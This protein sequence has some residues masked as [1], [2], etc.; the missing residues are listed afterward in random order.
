VAS[1]IDLLLLEERWAFAAG[2]RLFASDKQMEFRTSIS[3]A[4][5]GV[6]DSDAAHSVGQ[7]FHDSIYRPKGSALV[8]QQ[9]P[10]PVANVASTK[11]ELA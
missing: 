6:Y 8:N 2:L 3:S 11:A 5:F 10:A 9:V 7:E 1:L 4:S